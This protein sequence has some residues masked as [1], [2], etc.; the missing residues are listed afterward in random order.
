MQTARSRFYP[1]LTIT[2][3]GAFTNS[4]GGA[5]INP[6]KMLLSAV[7]SL[8]QP[9]F[10]KGQLVAGLKV[11]E[12]QYQQAF[13][14]WQNT[15]LKAGNEV[16]N[17]LVVYHSSDE[18]S[19]LEATQIAILEKNVEDTRMLFNSSGSTYLEI[20]TA[21]QS[22]LNVRLSKVVDDFSKMQ[23]VVNLYQALGGGVN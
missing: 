17:A 5:V 9:I 8:V 12:A 4:A 10:M 11:A 15:V 23:A 1:S 6:G 7:G 19:R 3:T 22:L 18:K 13:N 2:A 20:I 14:T 21:Q 16:S